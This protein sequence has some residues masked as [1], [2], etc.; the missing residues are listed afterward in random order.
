[1]II[2]RKPFE[3]L[4][5]LMA[6]PMMNGSYHQT[7]D[8]GDSFAKPLAQGK[9]RFTPASRH[10]GHLELRGTSEKS[11]T[12]CAPAFRPGS[13]KAKREDFVTAELTLAVY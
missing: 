10:L 12:S 5:F 6:D 7:D 11:R 3:L 8:K 2:P 9:G 13:F 4:N 1:M